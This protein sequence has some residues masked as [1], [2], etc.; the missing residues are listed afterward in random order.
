[1]TAELINLARAGDGEAFRQLVGPDVWIYGAGGFSHGR[2]MQDYQAAGADGVQVATRYLASGENPGVFGDTGELDL[3]PRL[4]LGMIAGRLAGTDGLGEPGFTL[5]NLQTLMLNDRNL[6]ADLGRR[7]MVAMCQAHPTLAAANG[8]QIDVRQACA[9][10]A[11]WNGR[12]DLGR[13]GPV[14]WRRCST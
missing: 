2:D 11:G 1:M 10:L 14:L 7:D 13:A 3:R 9:T 8:E 5:P 6:S 4:G 12:A